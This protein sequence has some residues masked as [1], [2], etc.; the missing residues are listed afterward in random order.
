M[1][2][3]NTFSQSMLNS[4]SLISLY[5][6]CTLIRVFFVLTAI[7]CI[8]D[9]HSYN[10]ATCILCMY[11][12]HFL[13]IN[14]GITLWFGILWSLWSVRLLTFLCWLNWDAATFL[15]SACWPTLLN[16]NTYWNIEMARDYSQGNVGR[17]LPLVTA[18][19]LHLECSA[20][21]FFFFFFWHNT[22]GENKLLFFQTTN[23]EVLSNTFFFLASL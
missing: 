10:Q 12:T 6:H 1:P 17:W 15:C 16:A 18:H 21:V 13:I 9:T 3:T 5:C 4:I 7:Y 2:L 14:Y 11:V 8:G 19:P 20:A 23:S 22:V